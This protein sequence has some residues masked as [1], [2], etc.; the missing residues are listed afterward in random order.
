M[1]SWFVALG[2]ARKRRNRS[3]SFELLLPNSALLL[4]N[5][6]K[7]HT[8]L[9]DIRRVFIYSPVAVQQFLPIGGVVLSFPVGP[10]HF[11]I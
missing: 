11:L 8:E 3:S 6:V 10:L 1:A 7:R 2:P 5:S 9:T 4:F